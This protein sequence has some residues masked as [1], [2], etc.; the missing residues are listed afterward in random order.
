MVRK[1]WFLGADDGTSDLEEFVLDIV[2]DQFLVLALCG[3]TKE[4]LLERFFV[5]AHRTSGQI[6]QFAQ[7]GRSIV[8]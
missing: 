1:V 8:T 2:Q 7:D 5:C 3:F 6:E 4:I